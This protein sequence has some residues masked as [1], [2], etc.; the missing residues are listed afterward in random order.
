LAG[1]RISLLGKPHE[2]DRNDIPGSSIIFA[3]RGNEHVH[4]VVVFSEYGFDLGTIFV[5][6]LVLSGP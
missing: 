1:Q 6:N 2:T 4:F 3:G 5:L